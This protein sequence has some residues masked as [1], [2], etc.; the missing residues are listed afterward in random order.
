M[1]TLQAVETS[2]PIK[3]GSNEGANYELSFKQ[4]ISLMD[5][6]SVDVPAGQSVDRGVV[7]LQIADENDDPV[8][9]WVKLYPF[10]NA[11]D[12]SPA[13]LTG[14]V[15]DPTDDGSTG[16]DFFSSVDPFGP[17]SICFPELAYTHL[18][19]TFDPFDPDS[20][21]GADGPGLDGFSVYDPVD[22]PEHWLDRALVASRLGLVFSFP[23]NPGL[24]EIERRVVEPG[25]CYSPRPFLPR[26]SDLVWSRAADRETARRLAEQRLSFSESPIGEGVLNPTHHTR[27]TQEAVAKVVAKNLVATRVAT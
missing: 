15:F 5:S 27:L 10:Q 24:D 14:C 2:D 8:G 19:D 11:Y 1:G 9:P 18:G 20:L 13:V 7:M 6:R 23:I 25:S 17:S 26:T 16:N 4:Q 12:Q 22:T 3:L 21:G